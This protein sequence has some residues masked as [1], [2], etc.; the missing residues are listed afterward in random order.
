MNMVG[1]DLCGGF[2]GDQPECNICNPKPLA[3]Y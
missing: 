2:D 3:I 1:C